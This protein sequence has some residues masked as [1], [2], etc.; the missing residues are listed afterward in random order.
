MERQTVT[1]KVTSEQLAQLHTQP[2]PLRTRPGEVI[3]D[4]L[5]KL[6]DGLIWSMKDGL[7][8]EMPVQQPSLDAACYA[9]LENIKARTAAALFA[10]D[11]IL[12]LA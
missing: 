10:V 4:V 6:P 9:A 2:L 5:V 8:V 3:D 7:L 11:E 1:V 12:G